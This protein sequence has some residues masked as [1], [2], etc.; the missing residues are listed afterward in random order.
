MKRC[1]NCEYY[2]ET[3]E[4]NQT[5]NCLAE[6]P[7]PF[8]FMVPR[9]SVVRPGQVEMVTQVVSAR[10][11]TKGSSKCALFEPRVTLVS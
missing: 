6:P 9:E 3:H 1:S 11:E 7:K 2:E 10:P 4:K 8:C 5:G